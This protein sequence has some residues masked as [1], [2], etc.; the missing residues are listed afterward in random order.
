[1]CADATETSYGRTCIQPYR[2]I[3]AQ[4]LFFSQPHAAWGID[5]TWEQAYA[6]FYDAVATCRQHGGDLA[7]SIEDYGAALRWGGMPRNCRVVRREP[8]KGLIKSFQVLQERPRWMR[9]EPVVA[10]QQVLPV[11]ADRRHR[12]GGPLQAVGGHHAVRV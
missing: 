6:N 2:R 5:E 7:G 12:G 3:G 8:F 4:C 10:P 11:V 9:A 1:M